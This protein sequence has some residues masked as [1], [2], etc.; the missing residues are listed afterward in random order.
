MPGKVGLLIP[1]SQL[2][3]LR[4]RVQGLFK[5]TQGTDPDPDPGA[6]KP[7]CLSLPLALG[8]ASQFP[9]QLKKPTLGNHPIQLSS[10]LS[11]EL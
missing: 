4:L 7:A 9:S 8:P 1:I 11:P 5:M 2:R 6:T 10:L 3:K